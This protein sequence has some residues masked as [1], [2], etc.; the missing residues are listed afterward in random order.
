MLSRRVNFVGAG[1]LVAAMMMVGCTTPDSSYCQKNSDCTGGRICSVALRECVLPDAAAGALDGA[2]ESGGG[3]SVSADAATANEADGTSADAP[4]STEPS[5]AGRPI[6]SHVVDGAGSDVNTSEAAGRDDVGVDTVGVDAAG[7]CGTNRDCTDPTE[8]FCVAGLCTGCQTAGATAC[9]TQV[10]DS[11]AGKCVECTADA[12]CTK[13]P[14]K[15]FCVANT[16]TGCNATGATGCSDRTDGK[17]VCSTTGAASGQCVECAADTQCTKDPAKGFCVA[18]ACT[19]CNA[20]GATGCSA[21]TDGR[22]VCATGGAAAGQCVEC[23]ADTQ[24][25]SDP[26]KGFCVA[27]ACTGCSTVG[28]TGCTAR[29]DGKVVCATSGASSGQ[30]VE[31]AADS[32]CT[33]SPAKGFCVANAC[34]GCNTP[35]ATGCSARTDG[36][37]VCPTSGAAAGQCVECTAD[38]QCTRDASKSFCVANACSGCQAAAS[39]ACSVRSAATPV[40]GTTGVCVQC[41]TSADCAVTTQPICFSNA[42]GPCTAD[43]Q[44]SAKLGTTGNPGVCMNNIDGHCATDAETVYVQYSPATCLNSGTNAGAPST[45]FCTARTGVNVAGTTTGKTLVVLTGALADFSISVPSKVLTVVGKNAVIT[46]APS[47]DGIDITAGEVFLRSI[48][49]QGSSSSGS[50]TNP[51]INAG[52]GTTLHINTCAVTGN[53]GGGILLNGGAFDIENTTVTANGPGTALGS[54]ASY[55]GIRIDALPASGSTILNLVTIQN[56]PGPGMSCS[57]TVQ[58]TGVLV[59]GNTLSQVGTTCGFTSCSTSDGGAACGAQSTP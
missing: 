14:S 16:C 26:A 10:C 50:Q 13:D 30:C 1:L 40:C 2:T 54:G 18:N 15:A 28:A 32:Q 39:D 33:S 58:G 55:G 51:G 12:Q 19:G 59:T 17:V 57:G 24:C 27:N 11:V 47:T 44:C 7:T 3:P 53:L 42:C 25:T 31:C 37:T 52:T 45:P 29:T 8:A 41:N 36:K 20:T 22:T 5:E 6:D 9:G 23:A 43:S 46:P 21:R 34:T 49:V 35:G 56:N 48:A 4:L 38:S